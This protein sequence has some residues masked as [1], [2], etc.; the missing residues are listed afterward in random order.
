M[1]VKELKSKLEDCDEDM[2][3]VIESASNIPDEVSMVLSEK[4]KFR[5]V[6][7][8]ILQDNIILLSPN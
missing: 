1:T 5:S 3:V 8:Q 4:G 6:M 2:V 7:G